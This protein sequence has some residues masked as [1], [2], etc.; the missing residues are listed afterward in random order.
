MALLFEELTS[1]IIGC[2][3]EV[4]KE[5]G[6]GLL[7]SSYEECLC[8]ELSAAGLS[9]QRQLALPIRYKSIKLDAGYRMDIVV[10]DKIIL[11]LKSVEAVT[12]LHEAQLLTYL[13]LARKRVG[14]IINF[15]VPKIK[16][17][18]LRRVL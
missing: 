5:L 13:R 2:A 4:H 6:P 7:E 8:Y 18:V 16:E 14:L 15:N 17:G 1:R 10:E 9:F 12:A 3:M 11:E